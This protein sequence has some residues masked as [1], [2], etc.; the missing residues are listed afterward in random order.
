MNE[1]IQIAR[2]VSLKFKSIS[3]DEVEVISI[4]ENGR[5]GSRSKYSVKVGTQD[6]DY[7]FDGDLNLKASKKYYI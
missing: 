5:R 6:T 7:Y 4:R 2:Q 3:E 1:I